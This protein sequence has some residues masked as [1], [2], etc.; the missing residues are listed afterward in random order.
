VTFLPNDL[1]AR[2]QPCIGGIGCLSFATRLLYPCV[3]S[4]FQFVRSLNAALEQAHD[5]KGQDFV[6][7][8]A[9]LDT[10]CTAAIVENLMKDGKLLWT[11]AAIETHGAIS[12]SGEST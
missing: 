2:K 1:V 7:W 4:R 11:G 12:R 6:I 10:R 3:Q 5:P 9:G 8:I